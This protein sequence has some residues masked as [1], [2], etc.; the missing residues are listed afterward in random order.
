MNEGEAQANGDGGKASRG[1]AICCTNDDEQEHAG[2]DCFSD[3]GGGSTDNR[4]AEGVF[5]IDEY[6]GPAV[7][8]KMA[9]SAVKIGMTND[10]PED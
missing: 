10:E 4:A 2:Q 6:I 3:E 9:D 7:G 8:G 1:T 5:A